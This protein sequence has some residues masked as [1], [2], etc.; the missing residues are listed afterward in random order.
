MSNETDFEA[1]LKDML[2]DE[3]HED[4]VKDV[5]TFEEYGMLTHNSGLV[6]T[7]NSGIVFELTIVER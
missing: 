2:F 1:E 4:V 6:V 3:V 5:T 7:L